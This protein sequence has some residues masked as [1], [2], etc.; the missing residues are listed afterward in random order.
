LEIVDQKLT[1]FN[2]AVEEL[3]KQ[4]Q[5]EKESMDLAELNHNTE[6]N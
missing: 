5:E 3:Q 1:W 6:K 4:V 2:E